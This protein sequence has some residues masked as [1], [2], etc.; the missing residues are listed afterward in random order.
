MAEHGVAIACISSIR[1][2]ILQE[3]ILC[4]GCG[5]EKPLSDFE[6]R[7]DSQTYRKTCQKCRN[8]AKSRSLMSP[9]KLKTIREVDKIKQ[10]NRREKSKDTINAQ[11]RESYKENKE[12][13]LEKNKKW[14][15]ENWEA[16]S[17]Q[18]KESGYNRRSQKRWYHNKGKFNLQHVISERL[19]SRVRKALKD[20]GDKSAEKAA[21]TM[22]LIGCSV[23]EL[24][25]HLESQF[26]KGMS[27][28]NY[29]DWHIDHIRPCISFNLKDPDQQKICFHYTNL[30]PLWAQENLKKGGTW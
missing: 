4:N 18:R 29:G 21:S 7:K 20:G 5:V 17:K 23:E 16:V 3:K 15:K 2:K 10:R 6:F 27:W 28:G 22:Q 13:I 12:T 24:I 8:A 26:E 25:G 9:E 14:R 1:S 19:R 30:Q 11:R